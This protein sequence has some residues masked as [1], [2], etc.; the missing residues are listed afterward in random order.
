MTIRR[1]IKTLCLG[2]GTYHEGGRKACKMGGPPGSIDAAKVRSMKAEGM[3]P[4]AQ[5]W[6]GIGV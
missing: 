1:S 5:D 2:G 3:G 4:L 6:A